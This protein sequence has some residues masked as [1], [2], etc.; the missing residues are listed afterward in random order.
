MLACTGWW[1]KSWEWVIFFSNRSLGNLKT[2]L[3]V[4][5]PVF[6][7][8]CLQNMN[9]YLR[10]HLEWF[11]VPYSKAPSRNY[12]F[13]HQ[14]GQHEWKWLLSFLLNKD[15]LTLCEGRKI[16]N[17]E[18]ELGATTLKHGRASSHPVSR[19][20]TRDKIPQCSNHRS[21]NKEMV[22]SW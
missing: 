2:G 11:R 4:G 6:L 7:G 16:S 20:P 5:L 22:Q 17:E 19:Q 15:E 3:S 9:I 14:L 18:N 8:I 12:P 1:E 21:R 10:Y 13:E